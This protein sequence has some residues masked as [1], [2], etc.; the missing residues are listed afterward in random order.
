M[1]QQQSHDSMKKIIT[2]ILLAIASFFSLSAFSAEAPSSLADDVAT[3]ET[4][5][6]TVWIVM[7]GVLVFFMQTGFAMLESGMVRSKNTVN[8]VLKNYTDMCFGAIAFWLIGYG[9]MFGT[10]TTGF[11]GTDHFFLGNAENMDYSRLFFHIMIAA[12]AATIVSGALAERARFTAY[13]VACVFIT[14]IIY[15]IFGSW[16][17]G[18]SVYNTDQQGWLKELEFID[19]AG[20]TVVHSVGGWSALAGVIVLGPRLGKYDPD[21]KPRYIAGHN[22]PLVAMGG[23]ILWI[24]WFGFNG[25]MTMNAEASIGKIVL[26]T[27][28]AGAAGVVGAVIIMVI[29]KKPILMTNTI[30]GSL[31]GLVGVTAGC[32]LFSPG[33][34]VLTGM[35]SGSIVILAVDFM[36]SKGWDDPIGAVAVHGF[37]GAWGTLA[38]GLFYADNMFDGK[39]I[40][41]QFVGIFACFIWT[42]STAF[43]LFKVIDKTM[44]LRA[45]TIAQQR[46]LDFAEHYEVGYPEFQKDVLHQGKKSKTK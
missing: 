15:P 41:I 32:D 8:V 21:G 43:L 31:G 2:L 3:L 11:F 12:T 42:F 19:F 35:I 28:L 14:A 9:L 38:A 29:K 7:A 13:L 36:D 45:S 16:A 4:S 37:C 24:G 33:I 18:G 26:N 27:H 6:N 5:L 25:G 1:P 30:Y 20:A 22:L 46:G 39:I 40:I 34:S 17:W 23:F 44:G 10:N